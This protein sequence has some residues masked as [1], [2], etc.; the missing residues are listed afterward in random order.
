MQ[1]KWIR[2]TQYIDSLNRTYRVDKDYYGKLY[3]IGVS[4]DASTF[5]QLQLEGIEI[6][7]LREMDE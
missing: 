1:I 5:S 6:V 4:K 2:H 3:L 7:G